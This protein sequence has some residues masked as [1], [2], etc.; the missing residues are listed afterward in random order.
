MTR[1][2]ATDRGDQPLAVWDAEIRLAADRF[3]LYD[4]A[5]LLVLV[6]L[7]TAGI[8]LLIS[9]FSGKL[10]TLPF[11]LRIFFLIAAGIT[12][13]VYLL[14]LLLFA[15]RYLM[16]FALT[17]KAVFWETRSRAGRRAGPLA[18]IVGLLAGK[19]SV[20][21]A[22]ALAIAGR[23][24]DIAW[25]KIRRIKEYPSL[26]VIALKNSWRVVAR[27]YCTA[28]NFGTVAEIVRARVG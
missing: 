24:G 21:G 1:L 28:E 5:K 16:R 25:A 27:L 18:F 2:N 15:N 17:E 10:D 19:P 23:A 22:G 9:A 13:L 26:N 6:F 8:S 11:L 7:I 20:A 4:L 14:S 12:V 3:F